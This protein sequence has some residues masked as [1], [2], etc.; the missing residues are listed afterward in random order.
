M[1]DQDEEQKKY[2]FDV[3]EKIA[4]SLIQDK[5][6]QKKGLHRHKKSEEVEL[7]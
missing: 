1:I 2:V 4:Q 7:T 6:G 3:K 5:P